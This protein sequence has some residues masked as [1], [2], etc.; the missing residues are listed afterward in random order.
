[1]GR[2]SY[3]TWE[4]VTRFNELLMDIYGKTENIQLSHILSRNE[5]EAIIIQH[6]KSP[7]VVISYLDAIADYFA[8][9][10]VIQGIEWRL[11]QT[12]MVHSYGL[13]TGKRHTDDELC[14]LMPPFSPTQIAD[15]CSQG[16]QKLKSSP[17]H[18][19][20]ILISVAQQHIGVIIDREAKEAI[21]KASS[22][23]N[24]GRIWTY[25]DEATLIML[26]CQ[27][28]E[29]DR[30]ADELMRSDYAILLRLQEI[31]HVE[32]LPSG[33]ELDS[34][35]EL[36]RHGKFWTGLEDKN[37][38]ALYRAQCSFVDIAEKLSRSPMAVFLRIRKLRNEQLESPRKVLGI[39]KDKK[40]VVQRG[41]WGPTIHY[42]QRITD[43]PLIY[44]PEHITA[45]QAINLIKLDKKLTSAITKA[46]KI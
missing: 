24:A 12:A 30:I 42:G 8:N 15:F 27:G 10:R 36:E 45:E 40:L 29:L 34:Y 25:D 22:L 6:L 14:E 35:E 7:E 16:T 23:E 37:L 3:E 4:R 38:L 32:L 43:V 18:L 44:N 39:Y 9:Q 19:E 41:K 2:Y 21:P 13:L 33:L 31:K 17:S 26:F 5:V 46:L 1:M 20:Q 11:Q 28:E